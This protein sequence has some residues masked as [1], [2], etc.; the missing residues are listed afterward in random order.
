[1]CLGSWRNIDDD[2]KQYLTVTECL[3]YSLHML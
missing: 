2:K 1:V 3:L